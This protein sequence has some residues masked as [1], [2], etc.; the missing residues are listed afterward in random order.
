MDTSALPNTD[1]EA[2][3]GQSYEAWAQ[4]YDAYIARTVQTLN[5]LPSSAFTPDLSLLDG[6][7]ET[8]TIDR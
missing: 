6:M 3:G 2:L 5:G 1:E 4:G 7:L 8:L